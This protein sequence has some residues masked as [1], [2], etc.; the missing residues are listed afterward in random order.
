MASAEKYSFLLICFTYPPVLGGS[1]I[2]AQRVCAE[3]RKRGHDVLVLCAAHTDMPLVR[4]WVDP[5]GVPVRILGGGTPRRWLDHVFALEVMR[6]LWRGRRKYRLVYFL[7]QGLHLAAG[8]PLCRLL[9]LRVV[10]KISGSGIVKLMQESWLGRLELRWLNRWAERV[11]VLNTGME[12]EAVEAGIARERLFWMPNPVDV[13]EFAP[14]APER[15]EELRA[16]FGYAKHERVTV[17][18][19]RLAPEKELGSLLGAFALVKARM[20]EARLLVIGDGPDRETL[21]AEAVRLGLG[22]EVRFTGREPMDRVRRYLQAGDAFALVSRLEGF[23]CSLIEAMATGLASV[24]SR[25]PANGQLVEDGEHGWS[26]EVG[27]QDEIAAGLLKLL[28]DEGMRERMG[29]AARQRIV[30]N[31]S[32]VKIAERYE[33]LLTIAAGGRRLDES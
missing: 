31:Y 12:Q 13:E 17:Y 29:Q 1:E 15:R 26:A 9:G 11:M 25:I 19:G 16:E 22:E 4:D 8:L 28:M 14:A 20:P 10:M 30:G 6:E 33:E 5:Y 3:M 2:E 21:Q 24:V 18:V 27:S 7:M 23:P 32:S